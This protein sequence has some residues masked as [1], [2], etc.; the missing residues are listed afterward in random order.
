VKAD[1][2]LADQQGR[3][4]ATAA[5]YIGHTICAQFCTDRKTPRH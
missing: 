3:G 1:T 2:G 5:G 4:F